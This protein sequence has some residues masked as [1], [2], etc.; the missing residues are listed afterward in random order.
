[1]CIHKPDSFCYIAEI[2]NTVKQL[3]SKRK[4]KWVTNVLKSYL[5]DVLVWA[6]QGSEAAWD[7]VINEKQMHSGIRG[8][9]KQRVT[10]VFLQT[11]P[12]CQPRP[13]SL[14]GLAGVRSQRYWCL[15]KKPFLGAHH[16][17]LPKKQNA[18]HHCHPWRTRFWY[19]LW[20]I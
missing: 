6:L 1:M 15:E 13:P 10:G 8:K 20:K 16:V 5:E 11:W 2:N 7:I 17:S 18:L 19:A 4:K 9:Q 14:L 12:W 3:Y